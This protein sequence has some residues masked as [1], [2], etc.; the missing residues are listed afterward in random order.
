MS[1]FS[2]HM[3][4]REDKMFSSLG[5]EGKAI[6]GGELRFPPQLASERPATGALT[7][8]NGRQHQFS[9]KGHLHITGDFAIRQRLARFRRWHSFVLV[10]GGNALEQLASI[11]FA[12]DNRAGPL[13]RAENS[14]FDIQP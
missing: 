11:Y 8:S 5:I 14:F 7:M 3:A 12:G 1:P 10:L 4:P 2:A 6:T 9:L 13:L